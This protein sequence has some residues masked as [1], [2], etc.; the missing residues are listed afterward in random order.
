M[1][2]LP[3]YFQRFP[4]ARTAATSAGA[5]GEWPSRAT[6]TTL[7]QPFEVLKTHMAAN[8]QDSLRTA[9]R[10]TVKRGGFFGFYQGLIPWVSLCP[11]LRPF[12]KQFP[13]PA[14]P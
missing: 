14:I 11:A 6:R 1:S 7:G 8:R 10:K 13:S 4:T 2:Y 5:D 3:H 12:S 9:I